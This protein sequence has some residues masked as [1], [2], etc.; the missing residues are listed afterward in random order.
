MAT[1]S[2]WP[3]SILLSLFPPKK[4]MFPLNFI[5]SFHKCEQKSSLKMIDQ[6]THL[7]L[8]I[9]SFLP[10][11][12]PSLLPSFLFASFM[13]HIILPHNF[14]PNSSEQVQKKK[15]FQYYLVMCVCMN[16]YL[17]VDRYKNIFFSGLLCYCIIMLFYNF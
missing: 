6:E 16:S 1:I 17:C 3:L 13:W 9:R 2:D 11:L 4:S 15:F 7:R 14:I 10:S 8:F 5:F 12:F